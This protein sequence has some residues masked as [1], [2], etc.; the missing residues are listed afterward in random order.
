MKRATG[1]VPKAEAAPV[2]STGGCSPVL[3]EAGLDLVAEGVW[4]RTVE[5]RP[6]EG[7]MEDEAEAVVLMVVS[8]AVAEAEAE[9]DSAVA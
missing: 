4:E 6:C 8:V 9:L 1:L 2:F 3:V 5:L 7:T